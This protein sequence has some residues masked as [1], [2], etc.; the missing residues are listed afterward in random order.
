MN[1]S[2]EQKSAEE[3]FREI[4]KPDIA[5]Q[6]NWNSDFKHFDTYNMIEFAHKYAQQQLA[7]VQK[8]N[9]RFLDKIAALK[10]QVKLLADANQSG[11]EEIAAL[12][13][14]KTTLAERVQLLDR[15][16]KDNHEQSQKLWKEQQEEIERLK[17]EAT[18]ANQAYEEL[19]DR[20]L[21]LLRK[22]DDLYGK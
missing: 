13:E 16:L 17:G 2:Q 14:E 21:L 9:D 10:E 15:T 18:R 6:Q 19:N 8:E 22:Y 3:F 20:Y 5:T 12:K 4:F 1:N 7:E 11:L